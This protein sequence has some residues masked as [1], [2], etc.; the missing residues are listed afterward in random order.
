MSGPTSILKLTNELR[1]LSEA[2]NQVQTFEDGEFLEVIKKDVI[3]YTLVHVNIRTS[4]K[5]EKI[6]TYL[7]EL[8]VMDKTMTDDTNEIDVSSNT[9]QIWT[10]LYNIITY[11]PRWQEIG[12]AEGTPNPQ[13]FRNKGADVVTGWSGIISIDIYED[14]GYCD[15]PVTG[16][17]YGAPVVPTPPPVGSAIYENSD[18]SY[19]QTIAGGA[20]GIGPDITVTDSDGSTSTQPAN[21]D[22]ICTP[23]AGGSGIL[24]QRPI[25]PGWRTSFSDYDEGWQRANNTYDYTN[26]NPATIARLDLANVNPFH[27]LVDDNSFGNKAR[28]T[29]ENGYYYTDP[30]D[31]ATITNPAGFASGYVIDHLTGLGWI[32][33]NEATGSNWATALSNAN[34]NTGA[35][36]T[37]WRVGNVS[38]YLSTFLFDGDVFGTTINK[39]GLSYLPFDKTESGEYWT[40]TT[41]A[42]DTSRAVVVYAAR[43]VSD[44]RININREAKTSTTPVYRICRN[45]F[46]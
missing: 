14:A 8:S 10:D 33:G 9:H 35:G 38:E 46:T 18:G 20:T 37:D 32:R 19:S 45:H 5:Q 24:Y 7:I 27:F 34:S 30:Y 25:Y 17:D 3:D 41:V 4:N 15:V 22:V 21:T 6:N 16:Y 31:I 44:F 11:S 12:V 39:G 36:Y 26:A 1:I 23:G 2:H 40:A 43:N 28:F 42:I 29:D 13:K